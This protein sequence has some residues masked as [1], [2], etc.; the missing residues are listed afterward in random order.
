MQ[1]LLE[2]FPSGRTV[3]LLDNFEDVVDSATLN[4][5]DTELGEALRALLNLPH[6]A[7]KVIL[8]TRIAPRDLALVQP[9][10]QT[11]LDLDEGLPSPF[12]ENILREMDT[13][14]KV[15]LKMPRIPCWPK[16]A[17]AHAATRE[18]WKPYLRSC[19]WI[20]TQDCVRFWMTLPTSTGK[21]GRGAGGR[22]LQPP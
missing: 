9:G 18:R 20:A 12:A 16:P 7:V 3:L 11:R 2:A 19:R 8:T 17:S 4:I 5:H 6:H 10:R 1:A 22:S 13:D 15:G 14:G 21:C